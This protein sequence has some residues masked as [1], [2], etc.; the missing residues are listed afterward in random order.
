MRQLGR[1]AVDL[2]TVGMTRPLSGS[3]RCPLATELA[4]NRRR[5]SN[6]CCSRIQPCEPSM[7]VT[8]VTGPPGVSRMVSIRSR[9]LGK[10]V[11]SLVRQARIELRHAQRLDQPRRLEG[12]HLPRL[13]GGELVVAAI[14]HRRRLVPPHPEPEQFVVA[15][16][17]EFRAGDA[18]FRPQPE[19]PRPLE[20][21]ARPQR[22][23]SPAR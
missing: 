14:V 22:G 5:A 13:A 15:A 21:H 8:L 1:R 9:S 4:S 20:G 7:I 2:T 12:Q 19:P 6:R 10:N 18:R 17:V 16:Q 11:R 3:R 23:E